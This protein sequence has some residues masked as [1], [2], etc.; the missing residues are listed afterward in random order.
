[1][2]GRNIPEGEILALLSVKHNVDPDMLF[3]TLISAEEGKRIL[4]DTLSIE[5]RWK[6]KTE[7][8][9]LIMNDSKVVAQLRVSENFLSE[10]TN[11]IGKFKDCERIRRHR[12]KDF[13]SSRLKEIGDLRVGM[14]GINLTG[15]EVL[16]I[17]EPRVVN[18]RYGE[19]GLFADALIGDKTGRVHLSLWGNQVGSISVGDTVRILNARMKEFRGVKQLQ[20]GK[21]GMLK[22]E[23]EQY[24][25]A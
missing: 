22:A 20:I 25:P 15:A 1:M 8:T 5:C 4:C 16:E 2:R 3:Q 14:V 7:R 19:Q 6:G 12:A 10:K 17:N 11:P 13:A 23:R 18:T 9:F 21:K 24:L